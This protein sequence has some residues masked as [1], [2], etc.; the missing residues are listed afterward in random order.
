MFCI[1]RSF[2]RPWILGVLAIAAAAGSAR[3]QD[4][5]WARLVLE[6]DSIGPETPRFAPSRWTPC[7]ATPAADSVRVV[8]QSDEFLVG[9]RSLRTRG[10]F[11]YGELPDTGSGTFALRAILC[12][13]TGRP[14][15]F[16]LERD[17]R[18]FYLVFSLRDVSSYRAV[19][20]FT[21][22]PRSCFRWAEEHG[23]FSPVA[24]P[25]AGGRKC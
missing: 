19:T 22:S 14:L 9:R 5:P 3:A 24:C 18:Y 7:A 16:V 2:V 15:T 10:M 1:S 20:L 4:D 21:E 23:R 25:G 17:H 8:G 13:E 12:N 11:T 6:A